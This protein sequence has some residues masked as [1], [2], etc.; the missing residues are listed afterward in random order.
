[1][2]W[3]VVQSDSPGGASG[4]EPA[5]Q[6][7]R[8]G[9]RGFESLAGCV[10]GVAESDMTERACT[11]GPIS[12]FGMWKSSPSAVCWRDCSCFT[13]WHWYLCQSIDQRCMGLFLDSHFYSIHL[14]VCSYAMITVFWWLLFCRKFWAWE[15]LV[16]QLYCSFSR[17]FWLFR[18]LCSSV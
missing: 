16:F 18:V 8:H 4:Q 7:R 3:G 1:M 10:R 11:R 5:C 15:M 6:C 9:R 2:V 12:F 14:Y 13:E 17:L